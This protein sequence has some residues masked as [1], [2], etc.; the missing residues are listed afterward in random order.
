MDRASV[1]VKEYGKFCPDGGYAIKLSGDNF[2]SSKG[3]LSDE[4][5]PTRSHL[6]LSAQC[7]S[8]PNPHPI[9]SHLR[10]TL[11]LT[12]FTQGDIS[13]LFNG[14]TYAAGDESSDG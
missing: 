4:N 8:D 7:S 2:G 14:K 5:L 11:T 10:L 6:S 12:P 1:C 3:D 9:R 13:V